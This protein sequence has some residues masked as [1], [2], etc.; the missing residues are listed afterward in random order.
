MKSI[1]VLILFF[2]TL[3]GGS[4]YNIMTEE[5]VPFNY[6]DSEGNLAGISV[7]IVRELLKIIGH[8]DNIK[9]MPWNR[10]YKMTQ[11]LP[12]NILF[13]MVRLPEREE[14]FK[15][16]G[17][18]AK[19]RW[20]VF[21]NKDSNISIN[22]L[23]ELKKSNYT[24]GTYQNDACELHLKK[25]GFAN[26]DSVY[27]DNLNISKLK[28]GRIDLWATGEIDAYHKAKVAGVAIKPIIPIKNFDLYIAFSPD[29]P[30]SEIKKW[31]DALDKLKRSAKYK[32]IVDKYLKG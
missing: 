8:K 4:E 26:L 5:S 27:D 20:V 13:P 19:N 24:I 1:L 25:E 10:S 29:T 6:T 22:S 28:N 11:K 17:P 3:F 15:W 9:I 21:A 23:A 16:V 12:N 2:A 18:F 31:Q 30:D 32:E 14:L 7:E